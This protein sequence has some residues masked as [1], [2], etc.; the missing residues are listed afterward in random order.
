MASPTTHCC[1]HCGFRLVQCTHPRSRDDMRHR[2]A[3]LNSLIVALTAERDSLQAESDAIVYPILCLPPETTAEIF[4]H[5]VGRKPIPSPS[6]APLLLT[7][8]CRQWRQVALATPRLWK[9]FAFNQPVPREVLKMWLSASGSLP[10]GLTVASGDSDAVDV[11]FGASLEHSRRWGEMTFTIPLSCLPRLH[12]GDEFLPLLRKI[13]VSNYYSGDSDVVSHTIAIRNAPALREAHINTAPRG[14]FDLPWHQLTTLTLRNINLAD[15]LSILE[16]C[17]VLQ[18]L[19]ITTVDS[20]APAVPSPVHVPRLESLRMSGNNFLLDYLTIP[21]LR[22][23]ALGDHSSL[24]PESLEAFIHRSKSPLCDIELPILQITPETFQAFLHAFP[25]SVRHLRLN[26]GPRKCPA[27]EMFAPL[28]TPNVLPR[29]EQLT[30]RG[31]HLAADGYRALF[32]AVRCRHAASKVTFQSARLDLVLRDY[33]SSR[34]PQQ[35][36][37]DL[38]KED[39]LSALIAQ[40]VR[41]RLVLAGL[42]NQGRAVFDSMEVVPP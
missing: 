2:L 5:C 19:S 20:I 15:C 33:F 4:G 41:V 26:W 6:A 10:L 34:T 8:V 23:L 28:E 39:S 31:R 1:P 37:D 7:Q 38:T 12:F 30:F 11:M 42:L 24:D 40:G 25:D 36:L 35:A 13:S 22:T 27:T 29:L 9:S 17:S 18:H 32:E 3:H 16:Q 21:H 14:N